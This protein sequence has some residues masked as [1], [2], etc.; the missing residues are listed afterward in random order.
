MDLKNLQNSLKDWTDIDIAAYHLGRS[1]GVFGE[2]V[3]FA[4]GAKGTL[5]TENS[6]SRSLYDIL[7]DLK[8]LDVLEFR[9]EPDFQYRWKQDSS[10]NT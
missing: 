6:I 3:D 10:T 8:T 5:W 4:T 1:L 7:S 2:D 9:E